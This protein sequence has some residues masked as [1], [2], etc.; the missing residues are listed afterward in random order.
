MRHFLQSRAAL[1]LR[2]ALGAIKSRRPA[3]LES[4]L[5]D[6]LRIEHRRRRACLAASWTNGSAIILWPILQRRRNHNLLVVH[7]VHGE[8]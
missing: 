4:L 5:E 8:K 3:A 7:N 2:Y 1:A 6:D